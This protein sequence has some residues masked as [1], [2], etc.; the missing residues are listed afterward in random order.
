MLNL[1]DLI[2]MP[3]GWIIAAGSCENS[4]KGIIVSQTNPGKQLVWVAVRGGSSDWA[5]YFD[6]R[7]RGLDHAVSNGNKLLFESNIRKLVPCSDEAYKKYR[8]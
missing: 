2:E 5:I 3:A 6:W 4:S 7:E 1:K 8:R